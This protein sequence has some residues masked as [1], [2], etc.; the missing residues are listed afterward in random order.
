MTIWMNRITFASAKNHGRLVHRGLGADNPRGDSIRRVK[1]PEMDWE[2]CEL[3]PQ[4]PQMESLRS[5]RSMNGQN[6]VP[7]TTARIPADAITLGGPSLAWR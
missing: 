1:H 4:G 7:M 6:A 3:S 5:L 2:A